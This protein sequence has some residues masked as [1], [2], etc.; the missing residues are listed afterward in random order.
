MALVGMTVWAFDICITINEEIELLWSRNGRFIK[1]L[2]LLNRYFTIVGVYLFLYRH[3]RSPKQTMNQSRCQITFAI[4]TFSQVVQ[5]ITSTTIFTMRLSIIYTPQS[6]LRRLLWTSMF[7]SHGVMIILYVLCQGNLLPGMIW[8][9]GIRMC[10][11]PNF[12]TWP[13]AA[14][15]LTP[16]YIDSLVFV[17]TV[18]HAIQYHAGQYGWK[19]ASTNAILNTLY[20]NGCLFYLAIILLRLGSVFVFF[21]APLGYQLLF[22]YLEYSLSSALT[23]RWFL[24][25]RRKILENMDEVEAITVVS[26]Q[27]SIGTTDL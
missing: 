6:A 19:N 4:V 27:T 3:R 20:V 11:L 5:V 2:Y 18:M 26:N 1:A 23:T 22:C 21:L 12:R 9:R 10:L 25:F 7:V 13:V 8:L 16:I 15:Y 14:I 24:S 17:I